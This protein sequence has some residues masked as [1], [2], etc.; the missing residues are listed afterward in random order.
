MEQ[1]LRKMIEDYGDEE[2]S[3]HESTGQSGRE[4]IHVQFTD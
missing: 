3:S 4:G 1:D 2:A